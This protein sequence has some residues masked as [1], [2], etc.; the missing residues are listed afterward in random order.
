MQHAQISRSI[1]LTTRCD[2]K[3]IHFVMIGYNTRTWS[4]YALLS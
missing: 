3:F 1:I 4:N 2:G